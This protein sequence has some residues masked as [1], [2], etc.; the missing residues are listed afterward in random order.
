MEKKKKKKWKKKMLARALK[1]C[2]SIH[3][4][5]LDKVQETHWLNI[6]KEI[7]V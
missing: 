6:F 7:P 5:P 3:I 1:A 4:E 2:S